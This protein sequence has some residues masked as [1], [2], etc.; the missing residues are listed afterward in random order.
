MSLMFSNDI[1]V[2]PQIL[3]GSK[4][5]QMQQINQRLFSAWVAKIISL[6]PKSVFGRSLMHTISY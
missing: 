6:I 2:G 3:Y 5:S 4:R 1:S